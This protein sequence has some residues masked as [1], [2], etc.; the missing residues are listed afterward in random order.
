M[1]EAQASSKAKEQELTERV[2]QLE[3]GKKDV[4]EQLQTFTEERA[5]QVSLTKSSEIFSCQFYLFI[6]MFYWKFSGIRSGVSVVFVR[7]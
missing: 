3:E 1:E 2:E 7:V 4:E 6:L 5:K